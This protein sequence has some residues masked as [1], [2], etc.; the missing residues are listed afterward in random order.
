LR[1]LFL[2]GFLRGY[3]LVQRLIA[4]RASLVG[5]FVYEEDPHERTRFADE[6]VA[7][8]EQQNVPAEKVRK[9]GKARAAEIAETLRPDVIF[10][11]GWRTMLPPEILDLAPH[12][13]VGAHDS[14]LP[15]LRGFA[16][17][18]WAVL[19]GHDDAGVTLLRLRPGVDEGE[20]YFQG[21]LRVAPEDTMAV[22][23]DRIA[24]V[25]VGL[26]DKYLD[27][28]RDG[29]LRAFP[30]QHACA[31]YTCARTPE[32]GEI[33]WSAPTDEIVRL[34]RALGPPA[35]GA[36]T[37]YDRRV[38][39]VLSATAVKTPP[40]YEGRIPGRVIARDAR[41][42]TID[43]LSGDGI[44]RIQE[45]ELDG[46]DP[47]PPAKLIKSVRTSLGLRPALEVARLHENVADLQR[48]VR[49]LEERL[50]GRG[51]SPGQEDRT[52]ASSL[53]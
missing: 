26:F 15:R 20:V 32:D 46:S 51:E 36:Y 6:T 10:C 13:V 22:L 50:A 12:G 45:V 21:A 18:N 7:L 3:R 23:V 27:A 31:T 47:Q 42:G 25:A 2:G 53:G 16:P 48:R 40:R 11:C 41:Q 4:R 24:D 52:A 5:A 29:S 17:T 37:Y 28:F 8:F 33:D 34:I 35:P 43:V 39:K 1:I 30:Q 44:V 49:Q 14:L 9:L 19:L 38:L